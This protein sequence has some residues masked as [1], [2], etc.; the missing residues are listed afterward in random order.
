MATLTV[1]RFDTA[2]GAQNA[3]AT[4]ERLQKEE[5]IRVVDAAVLTWP[6]DRKKPVVRL[7]P[8]G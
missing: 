3:L 2:D 7:T 4:L 6:A 5:L 8:H 1:W